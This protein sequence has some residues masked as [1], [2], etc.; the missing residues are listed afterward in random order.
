MNDELAEIKQKKLNELKRIYL[1]GGKTMEEMPDTSIEVTDADFND[2][3]SKYGT[4][5]VDCWAPWCGPCRMIAPV[6]EE[7]AKELQGKI[8][9]G[10]L[11]VDENQSTASQYGI[12]S[13]PSLLVFKEGKLVEKIIGALP[14][15]MLMEKLQQ[16]M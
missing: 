3:I 14:K 15:P 12:M 5:V 16:Y 11:N 7:L 4:I 8:V 6:V 2:N 1:S 13:I 9:F 10:K